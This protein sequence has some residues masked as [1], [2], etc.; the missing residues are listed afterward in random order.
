MGEG[1]GK[2]WSVGGLKPALRFMQTSGLLWNDVL[3]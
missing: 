1:E 3:T 2:G